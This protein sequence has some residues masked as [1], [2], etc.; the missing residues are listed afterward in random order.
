MK[1]TISCKAQC[2]DY[3]G[4][5]ARWVEKMEGS[6]SNGFNIHTFRITDKPYPFWVTVGFFSPPVRIVDIIQIG[7]FSLLLGHYPHQMFLTFSKVLGQAR[8]LPSCICVISPKCLALSDS[9][10]S[11]CLDREHYGPPS[12]CGLYLLWGQGQLCINLFEF[13]QKSMLDILTS[14]FIG[15]GIWPLASQ[16]CQIT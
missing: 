15:E 8:L 14:L 13:K 5:T 4:P 9:Q 11:P 1:Q 3:E 7:Y 10:N 2:H 6:P 16:K 12:P